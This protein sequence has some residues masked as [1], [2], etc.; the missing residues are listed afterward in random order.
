MH[1]SEEPISDS[2]QQLDKPINGEIRLQDCEREMQELAK[3][4]LKTLEEI[5]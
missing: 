1:I 2:L 4:R 5:I 3:L